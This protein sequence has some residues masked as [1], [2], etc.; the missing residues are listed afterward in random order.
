[1]DWERP[2]ARSRA[3]PFLDGA[4]YDFLLPR[5]RNQSRRLAG[6]EGEALVASQVCRQ[7][8]IPPDAILRVDYGL[9]REALGGRPFAARF[10]VEIRDKESGE[11]MRV[12]DDEVRS[13]QI[14]LVRTLTVSLAGHALVVTDVCLDAQPLGKPDGVSP[15]EAMVWLEPKIRSRPNADLDAEPELT[16]VERD[17][18]MWQLRAIGYVQ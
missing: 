15:Q 14:Q 16:Q 11:T 1:L 2:M 12:L 9:H 10:V 17:L 3:T 7:L 5:Q 18:R 8:I 4:L 13:D 6:W